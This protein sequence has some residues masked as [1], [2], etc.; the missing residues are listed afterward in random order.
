[1]NSNCH[2]CVTLLHGE[3]EEKNLVSPLEQPCHSLE[4]V[5]HILKTCFEIKETDLKLC[6]LVIGQIQKK[7]IP[8]R[9]SFLVCDS[10]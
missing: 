2:C 7:K 1:M 9:V 6:F 4:T 3:G 10:M 5:Q 8:T